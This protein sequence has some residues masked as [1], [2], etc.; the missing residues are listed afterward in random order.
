MM[1]YLGVFLF[2]S[3]FFGTLWAS[4][5]SWVYFLYQIGEVF[6]HYL[7]NK[8]SISCFCSSS[9]G[10]PIIQILECFRLSQRFV[11]VSSLFW[12]LVSSFWWMFIFSFCSKLFLWVLIFF[13]LLLVL[14][15][16]ALFNFGYPSFV[17]FIFWP[18]SIISDHFDY[19]SFK[20]SIR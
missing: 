10:I 6:L 14:E 20:F 2:G 16:F 12:I 15:H 5:T 8:F 17:F 3:N 1:M 19:Q 11:R 18:S 9:S 13:L 4:W 7:L